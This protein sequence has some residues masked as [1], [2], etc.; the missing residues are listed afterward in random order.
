MR[1]V[2][3]VIAIL[4]L[5]FTALWFFSSGEKIYFPTS[6]T[7]I[8]AFGDSLVYGVGAT[9]KDNFVAQLEKKLGVKVLNAG[10]SGDTT[11]TAKL[12]LKKDVLEKEPKIVIIV[13][14]GNDILRRYP[15][16]ETLGNLR[17][18][19]LEIKNTGSTVVLSGISGGVLGNYNSA[20]RKLASELEVNYVDD[21]LGGIL[22]KKDLM[23]DAIHPN[24][25]GY[26]KM[27]D[28]Y[29]ELLTKIL[30]GK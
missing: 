7:N 11:S 18:M 2:Y 3:V 22:G 29:R 14:G 23:Y 1:I 13:L 4:L 24:A 15:K 12:R 5:F 8:I 28:K 30:K 10:L 19:I 6:G 25:K 16:E 27:A 21:V 26:E 9:E 20:Y 17:E